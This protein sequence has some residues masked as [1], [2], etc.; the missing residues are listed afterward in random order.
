MTMKVWLFGVVGVCA[1]AACSSKS[2]D[3]QGNCKDY[4]ASASKACGATYDVTAC[5]ANCSA[6]ADAGTSQGVAIPAACKS[7]GDAYQSCTRSA[8]L[9]CPDGT[10]P[11]VTGCDQQQADLATCIQ[12]GG[13]DD[14]GGGGGGSDSSTPTC[15]ATGDSCFSPE[16]C[17]GKSCDTSAYTCN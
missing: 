1:V 9:T 3:A 11:Q 15:G 4:C 10:N 17:C 13:S 5:N 14:G 12:G 16:E 6:G 2:E 7:K 8:K